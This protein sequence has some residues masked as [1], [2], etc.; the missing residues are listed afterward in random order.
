MKY[1]A[2]SMYGKDAK[3]CIRLIENGFLIEY[4][5]FG[6]KKEHFIESTEELFKF[7][8]EIYLEKQLDHD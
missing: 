6:Q 7:L 2:P 8:E 4:E 5:K 1:F 3:I